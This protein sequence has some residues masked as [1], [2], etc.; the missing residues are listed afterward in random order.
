MKLLQSL[1]TNCETVIR[2]HPN[3]MASSAS[4]PSLLIER[5]TVPAHPLVSERCRRKRSLWTN[6]A[7][8]TVPT[9]QG[10]T[11]HV[12]VR[13]Q[14]T[15]IS[16]MTARYSKTLAFRAAFMASSEWLDHTAPA[17]RAQLT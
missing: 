17:S 11:G 3:A 1:R 8:N 7:P 14:R 15:K 4:R 10:H 6:H 2:K 12:Q 13:N 9:H 16:T 5:R